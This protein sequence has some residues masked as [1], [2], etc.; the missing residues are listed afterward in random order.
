MIGFRLRVRA[1]DKVLGGEIANMAQST[2]RHADL[3]AVFDAHIKAEF[4][5]TDVRTRKMRSTH[6]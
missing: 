6:G 4:A 3:G 5:D 2:P 1:S